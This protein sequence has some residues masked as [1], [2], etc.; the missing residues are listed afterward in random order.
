VALHR[1]HGSRLR[2][3][4]QCFFQYYE[5]TWTRCAQYTYIQGAFK[6]DNLRDRSPTSTPSRQLPH[7]KMFMLPSKLCVF[8]HLYTRVNRNLR[9]PL[10]SSAS[11]SL[12]HTGTR[13][14]LDPK[15]ALADS[16]S[17]P[18]SRFA[19]LPSLFDKSQHAS[20]ISSTNFIDQI[21]AL[22]AFLGHLQQ[23]LLEIELGVIDIGDRCTKMLA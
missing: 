8:L 11:R 19:S 15:E 23:K 1:R 21:V 9:K 16:Q 20:S 6:L 22:R 12:H 13:P 2:V 7:M 3:A 14:N 5:T 17:F 10:C 18:S 4:E